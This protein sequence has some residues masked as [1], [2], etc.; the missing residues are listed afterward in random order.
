[1]HVG[2]TPEY[3]CIGH[4]RDTRKEFSLSVTPQTDVTLPLD[5]MTKL[6]ANTEQPLLGLNKLWSGRAAVIEPFIYGILDEEMCQQTL[7][8]HVAFLVDVMSFLVR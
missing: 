4:S 2:C 3:Q 8:G 1:M 6:S 5:D 7:K